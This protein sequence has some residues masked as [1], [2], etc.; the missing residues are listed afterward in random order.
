MTFPVRFTVCS[1]NIWTTTRWPE[2]K[3]ALQRFTQQALPDLYCLQELQADSRQALD[4]VLAATHERVED[5][6]EGW[7]R[8]GNLYWNTQMF[9][10][11]EHGAEQIGIWEEFR[12]LF[13]ARLRLKDGSGR[14]VFV[15]TAHFTWG[16]NPIEL[17]TERNVRVA[18]ARQAVDALNRLQQPGEPQLFMGDLNDAGRP[19]Q[20]LREG[21]F[22]DCFMP[23]GQMPVHTWP[24][25]PT[26]KG[27]QQTIDWIMFRGAVRPMAAYI[28]DYYDGDL[29]PSDHKPVLATFAL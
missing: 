5:P 24:A 8:E 9:E 28:V 19:I 21:G 12:R 11:V 3:Q 22:S 2:R 15:S 18:Q 14:T 16:G 13:W 7:T 4:E 17:E 29:A 1:Y 26:A 10:R 27:P 25:M 20:V 23:L 6:F